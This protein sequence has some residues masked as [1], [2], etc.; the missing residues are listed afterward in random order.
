M[1]SSEMTRGRRKESFLAMAATLALFFLVAMPLE[2]Q[3]AASQAP[4]P[5]TQTSAT[6]SSKMPDWQIAAGG[7]MD[8]DVASVKQNTTAPSRQDRELQH[9]SGP[10]GL[11]HSPPAACFPAT[12]FPLAQYMIFAYKLTPNQF[13]PPRLPTAEMGDYRSV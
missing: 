6:Q 5:A 11:C 2:V 12:N 10:S 7:K 9:S 1:T 4:T 8:F 13:S 3:S